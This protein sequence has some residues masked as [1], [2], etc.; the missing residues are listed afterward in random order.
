MRFVATL[1]CLASCTAF[2]FFWRDIRSLQ[3]P[4]GT[5]FSRL[6]GLNILSSKL[7]AEQVFSKNY[8]R[9]LADYGRS[10]KPLDLK[11]AGIEG[12][13]AS[14]GDPH[15]NFFRPTAAKEFS[16]ETRATFGGVGARLGPDPLGARVATV[17]DD[18]PAYASG[19]RA[20]N[21]ITAVDGVSA[22]GVDI[23]AIV[24]RI[25][26]KVGTIVKLSVVQPGKDKPVVISIRRGQIIAP[27]VEGNVITGTKIGYMSIMQ[28]SEPTAD[29][30]D[31]EIARLE[32]QGITGLV[33][34]LRGNP[35]GLL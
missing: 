29:Q 34:D 15:T 21:L 22:S 10:V 16:D 7:T 24:D 35:G 2:G 31:H 33:I 9:I 20:G 19:L 27:T 1:L 3:A 6:F 25:K 18:G 32:A 4:S 28:F 30:F 5:S 17:F 14:L 11:Y 26:G 13:V 12:M 23:D 8:E